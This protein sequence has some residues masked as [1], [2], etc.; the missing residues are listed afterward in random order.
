MNSETSGTIYQSKFR[1][2]TE[3]LNF[4]RQSY[5]K[6]VVRLSKPGPTGCTNIYLLHH[7]VRLPESKGVVITPHFS[8]R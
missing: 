8:N 2:V 4:L 7:N 5:H 1:N 3:D 6:C